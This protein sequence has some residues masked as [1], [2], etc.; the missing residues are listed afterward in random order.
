L[1]TSFDHLIDAGFT[2]STAT[3][4]AEA[5]PAALR[6]VS[7]GDADKLAAAFG[8]SRVDQLA[9]NR[10]FHLAAAIT[11]AAT[12]R[13]GHDPGPPP[14]WEDRFL[15]APLAAYE[16]RPDLFRIDFGPV[17][18]RGRLDGTARLLVVGQDP[19]VNELLAHRNF[20]GQS[21]QRLQGFLAKLGITRSYLML[22]TFLFSIFGQFGGDN[23]A[24]SANGPVSDYRNVLFDA[25]AGSNPLHAIVTVGSG[26]R[27]AVDRWPGAAGVPRV[28]I[29]HP[30][31]PNV[32]SLL[33]DWNGA[34]ASLGVLVDPDDD[35]TV[36][37]PYGAAF[38]PGDIAGIPRRDLPFGLPAWHGMGDHAVRSGDDVIEW[39]SST[40]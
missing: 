5:N 15:A 14:D 1:A 6:G 21:G 23:A 12:G 17:Y 35:G 34:L 32:T 8:I 27:D 4:L 10:Y 29:L 2:G 28:H 31:F 40:V 38:V 18:Y 39:H 25:A 33:T 26:A 36:G 30:A 37:V 7:A 20:V 3:Q 19:S 24:M 22:N 16:A 11:A 13:P 9:G